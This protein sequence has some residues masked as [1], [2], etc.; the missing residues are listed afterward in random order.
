LE[1]EGR[2]CSKKS[3]GLECRQEINTYANEKINKKQGKKSRGKRE[4]SEEKIKLIYGIYSY[5]NKFRTFASSV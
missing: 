5:C 2:K 3:Y 1:E 4:R